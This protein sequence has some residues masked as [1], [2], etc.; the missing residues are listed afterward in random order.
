MPDDIALARLSPGAAAPHAVTAVLNYL[1]PPADGRRPRR[2][3]E[4]PPPGEP[5]STIESEPHTVRIEDVR[6]READFTLDRNGFAV[7]HAPSALAD[8]RD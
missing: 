6:G 3:V 7:L 8:L 1:K 5:K 4:E 2:Y